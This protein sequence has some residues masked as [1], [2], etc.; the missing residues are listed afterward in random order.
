MPRLADLALYQRLWWLKALDG[1]AAHALDDFP[2]TRDWM[3]RIAAV[4][5][6]ERSELSPR[7]ALRIASEAVP[8]DPP[9]GTPGEDPTLRGRGGG[10]RGDRVRVATEDFARDP[11]EGELVHATRETITVRRDDPEVGRVHVHFPRLGYA[12]TPSPK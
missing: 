10:R 11:V 4:G 8:D 12:V 6:G 1:R 3:A 7:E 9:R 2:R 5:Y